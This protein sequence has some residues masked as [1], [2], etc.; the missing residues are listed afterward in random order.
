M[1]LS[2][3][4][5]RQQSVFRASKS[6]ETTASEQTGMQKFVEAKRSD[7]RNGLTRR[8]RTFVLEKLVGLN[9]KDAALAAGYSLSVAENTKQ[10]IWK[11]R[12]RAEW[13][14]LRREVATRIEQHIQVS[15]GGQAVTTGIV[16]SGAEA[17]AGPATRPQDSRL[18]T[19]H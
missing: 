8:Q 15:D 9:D 2:L 17:V 10:R 19:R 7:L 16:A 5:T 4:T 13:E 18:S 3:R 12:V 6:D 1:K 14:R 11:P